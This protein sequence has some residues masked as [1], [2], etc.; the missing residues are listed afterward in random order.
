METVLPEPGTVRNQPAAAMDQPLRRSVSHRGT[1]RVDHLHFTCEEVNYNG[2]KDSH[3]HDDLIRR[4]LWFSKRSCWGQH[5]SLK[6]QVF[7]PEAAAACWGDWGELCY[8][9]M[10]HLEYLYLSHCLCL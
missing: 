2:G 10:H 1:E 6:W 7:I 5:L 4:E 9:F 8:D 3:W